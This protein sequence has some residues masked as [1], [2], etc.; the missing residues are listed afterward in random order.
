MDYCSIMLDNTSTD[1]YDKCNMTQG[2]LRKI[3]DKI[4]LISF[5]LMIL[6]C[7]NC[8]CKEKNSINSIN[9]DVVYIIDGDSKKGINRFI[10]KI[11]KSKIDAIKRIYLQKVAD[12]YTLCIDL[13][14]GLKFTPRIHTMAQKIRISLSFNKDTMCPY[15]NNFKHRLIKQL[16]LSQIGEK[17]LLIDLEFADNVKTL[18]KKYTKHGVKIGFNL[19]KKKRIIIDAG[20]GGNDPG[21]IGINNDYEK[22]MTLV[23]AKELRNLLEN[24]GKYDVIMLRENDQNYPID[25]RVATVAK[26]RADVLI[27]LHT[28]SNPDASMRG[29]SIYT[30]PEILN[31]RESTTAY[32]NILHRSR[33]LAQRIISYIPQNCKIKKDQ[34]RGVELK[35]LKVAMPAIL[36]ELGCLSNKKDH[37]LLHIKE[38]RNRMNRAILYALNDYFEQRQE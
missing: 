29:M 27:S 2:F 14:N 37:I 22:N 25:A 20:H 23:F 5:L 31:G 15:C 24:T 17:S 4:R 9:S 35:I 30:L 28:D 21:A 3:I 33:D 18:S 16:Q 8:L 7:C 36:I 19:L 26:T 13:D 12:V 32:M 34:C 38:F 11:T 10:D 6:I 1:V